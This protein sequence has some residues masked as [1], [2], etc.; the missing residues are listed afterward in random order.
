MDGRMWN[1]VKVMERAWCECVG[2]GEWVG[3]LMVGELM[4]KC[5]GMT[6]ED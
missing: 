2:M 3:E 6:T 4:S 5:V 1:F